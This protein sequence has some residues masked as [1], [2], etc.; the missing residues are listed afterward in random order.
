MLRKSLIFI[1]IAVMSL[2]TGCI[3]QE[4]TIQVQQTESPS[5]VYADVAIETIEVQP[6]QWE[7][8]TKS[9]MIVSYEGFCGERLVVVQEC[10]GGR[11][12]SFLDEAGSVPWISDVF[13]N[14]SQVFL[15]E[16]NAVV[17]I[18]EGKDTCLYFVSV[19]GEKDVY[20]RQ[21]KENPDYRIYLRF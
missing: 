16:Q 15:S 5:Q 18:K 13:P 20:K 21:H 1:W 10:E 14:I 4:R 11:Q 3:S 19:K 12:I 2:L 6:S 8:K 9:G 7:N 17:E